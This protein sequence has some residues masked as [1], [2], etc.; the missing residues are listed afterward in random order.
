[1]GEIN[2]ILYQGGAIAVVCFCFYFLLRWV[3]NQQERITKEHRDERNSWL[4]IMNN[5]KDSISSVNS[6]INDLCLQIRNMV[7]L[8]NE[9]FRRIRD[10]HDKIFEVQKETL[11]FLRDVVNNRKNNSKK[12][13][14]RIQKKISK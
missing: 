12:R 5:Y 10:E 1:M 14:K 3:L 8:Q 9:G 2:N 6:S 7:Q 13:I 11:E 4:Q